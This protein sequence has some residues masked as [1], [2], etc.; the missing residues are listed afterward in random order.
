MTEEA[1]ELY[2][3]RKGELGNENNLKDVME[4]LGEEVDLGSPLRYKMDIYVENSG[5]EYDEVEE[6]VRYKLDDGSDAALI[7]TDQGLFI[8]SDSNYISENSLSIPSRST[9][10]NIR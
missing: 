8:I 2:Y 4:G 7:N 10:Y 9:K 3:F 1:S 6:N 5:I